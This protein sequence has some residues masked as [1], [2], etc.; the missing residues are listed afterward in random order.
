MKKRY[1]IGALSGLA[2]AAVVTKLLARP[3]DVDWERNREIVFHAGHS[4]FAEVDGAR[5][6]YQEAGPSER[7][8]DDSDSRFCLVHARLEQGVSGVRR[9][10]VSSDRAGP[11]RVWLFRQATR[12]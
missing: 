9:Q 4:R 12:F 2:T 3:H 5:V 1:L 10:G 7:T 8:A 11:S 6:H